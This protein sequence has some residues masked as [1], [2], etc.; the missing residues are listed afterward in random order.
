[1]QVPYLW[2]EPDAGSPGHAAQT[3]TREY[4]NI[5]ENMFGQESSRPARE[6]ACHPNPSIV[7]ANLS[8]T[9]PEDHGGRS[10]WP[11]NP[12][13]GG[14]PTFSVVSPPARLWARSTTRAN[15]AR[16]ASAG[17]QYNGADTHSEPMG[18]DEQRWDGLDRVSSV[19]DE[20]QWPARNQLAVL[21]TIHVAINTVSGGRMKRATVTI[22]ATSS[23]GRCETG[24]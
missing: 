22:A 3:E 19:N 21:G 1:V 23:D 8:T 17:G 4:H 20:P 6:W 11:V 12:I 18:G 13:R 7:V 24:I 9:T 16:S 10:R 14:E 5:I 2:A 15:R